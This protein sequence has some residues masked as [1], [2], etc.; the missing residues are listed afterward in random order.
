MLLTVYDVHITFNYTT[1]LRAPS[2]LPS[3]I[4]HT[5][6]IDGSALVCLAL[7]QK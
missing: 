4:V 6:V 5:I 1:V 3:Y 7:I 2:E